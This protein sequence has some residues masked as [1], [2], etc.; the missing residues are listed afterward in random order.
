LRKAACGRDAIV[1]WFRGI[2]GDMKIE[3]WSIATT[4]ALDL[5]VAFHGPVRTLKQVSNT[6]INICRR[7]GMMDYAWGS[8]CKL[9]LV[10]AGVEPSWVFGRAA[11]MPSPP[12]N[13]IIGT[14]DSLRTQQ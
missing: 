8:N 12:W 7:E 5:L 1:S 9:I 3:I 4:L 11:P 14:R 13:A 6:T 10:V 2:R